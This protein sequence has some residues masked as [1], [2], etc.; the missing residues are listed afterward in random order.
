MVSGA[1][2]ST[3]GSIGGLT[4]TIAGGILGYGGGVGLADKFLVA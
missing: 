4:K 3:L 1:A 2:G